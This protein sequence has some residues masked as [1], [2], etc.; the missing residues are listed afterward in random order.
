MVAIHRDDQATGFRM[1][2]AHICQLGV[3]P[4]EG[5]G[6]PLTRRIKCCAKALGGQA[7]VEGIV[8]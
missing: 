1:R 7:R 6:H 3:G 2:L 8:K 5:V 4:C